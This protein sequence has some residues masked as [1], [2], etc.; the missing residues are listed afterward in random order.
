MGNIT[1]R[2]VV[3]RPP[4]AASELGREGPCNQLNRQELPGWQ[5]GCLMPPSGSRDG[6]WLQGSAANSRLAQPARRNRREYHL[7]VE[8]GFRPTAATLIC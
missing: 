3:Y 7:M 2:F 1:I 6:L 4:G 8:G 5:S